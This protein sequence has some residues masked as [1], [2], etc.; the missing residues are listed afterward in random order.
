MN[1]MDFQAHSETQLETVS[2]FLYELDNN[3]STK[4][5]L[6]TLLRL[7]TSVLPAELSLYGKV[8]CQPGEEY[9][10]DFRVDHLSPNMSLLCHVTRSRI[11]QIPNYATWKQVPACIVLDFST[12]RLRVR[13]DHT[14]KPHGLNI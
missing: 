9:S 14:R 3:P 6:F 1:A 10:Y 8:N 4:L 5:S 7:P 2:G 13:C 11:P 12:S